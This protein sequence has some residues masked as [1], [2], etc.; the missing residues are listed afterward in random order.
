MLY[1]DKKVVVD[2]DGLHGSRSRNGKITLTKGDHDI[3]IVFY[4][5]RNMLI[6]P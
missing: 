2:N 3:T 1:I 4:E 6:P 5:V